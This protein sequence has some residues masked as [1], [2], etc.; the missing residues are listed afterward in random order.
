MSGVKEKYKSIGI[1]FIGLRREKTAAIDSCI[2]RMSLSNP[3]S[4]PLISAREFHTQK[5]MK[6]HVQIL[7]QT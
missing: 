4:E 5:H 1:I 6:R 3:Q 2:E 7:Y